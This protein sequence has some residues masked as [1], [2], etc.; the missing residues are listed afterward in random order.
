MC[1]MLYEIVST[2][3]PIFMIFGTIFFWTV[4][5]AVKFNWLVQILHNF[6]FR[7]LHTLHMQNSSNCCRHKY[8]QSISR[9]YLS[10][11]WRIF[12]IWFQCAQWCLR[13]ICS[14]LVYIV[15]YIVLVMSL[16]AMKCQLNLPS[17]FIEC[18]GI[19]FWSL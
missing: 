1:T 18:L 6:R 3:N 7:S 11:Y 15:N 4:I 5:V 14:T 16:C 9:I 10:N 13:V 2:I 8:D 17:R 19:Q 12:V